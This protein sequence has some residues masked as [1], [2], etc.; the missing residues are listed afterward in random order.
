[1]TRYMSPKEVKSLGVREHLSMVDFPDVS[2]DG[3]SIFE[4]R[5]LPYRNIEEVREMMRETHKRNFK[6]MMDKWFP[7]EQK[8]D[9]AISSDDSEKC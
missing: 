6:E 1:M 9:N 2:D 5:K 4:T 8:A 3:C 7:E